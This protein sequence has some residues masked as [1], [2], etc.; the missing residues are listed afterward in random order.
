MNYSSWLEFFKS[1]LSIAN[2]YHKPDPEIAA[3]VYQL[4]RIAEVCETLR[5]G[6]LGQ[7]EYGGTYWTALCLE[8]VVLLPKARVRVVDRV[9]LTLV[10]EP[11]VNPQVRAVR[12]QKRSDEAA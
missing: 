2:A 6:Q 10:V 12:P 8:N 9:E 4:K 3:S 5:P 11:L 7:V 1:F